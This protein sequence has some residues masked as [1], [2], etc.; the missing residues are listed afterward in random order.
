MTEGETSAEIVL[1]TEHVCEKFFF[2]SLEKLR[3]MDC[4]N[5][6]SSVIRVY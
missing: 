1:T 6:I 4:V 5:E 2:N 3:G